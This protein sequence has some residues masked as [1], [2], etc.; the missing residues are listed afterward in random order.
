M[1]M[2]IVLSHG[3]ESCDLTVPGSVPHFLSGADSTEVGSSEDWLA[4][5][6]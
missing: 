6:K 3:S 1:S 4:E 2:M 5:E